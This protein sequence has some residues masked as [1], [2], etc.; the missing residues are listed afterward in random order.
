MITIIQKIVKLNQGLHS[1]HDTTR[2]ITH[3]RSLGCEED[4]CVLIDIG[5]KVE[6]V[7]RVV[8]DCKG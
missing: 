3:S 8:S 2:C 5:P 1:R 7:P 6:R 4:V